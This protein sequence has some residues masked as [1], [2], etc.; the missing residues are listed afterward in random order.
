MKVEYFSDG[1]AICGDST[2]VETFDLVR[3]ELKNEKPTLIISDPPYGNVV[4]DKW[5]RIEEDDKVF[6]QWMIEWTRMWSLLLE[7]GGAFY[8]WGGTGRPG[9]R[10]FFRYMSDVESKG[11]FELANLITWKK[12]RGYG[13][14]NNYLYTREECAY[15]IKGDAKKP[16]TFNV[17]YLEEKRGYSGYD[18]DYPALS[19]FYRRTNVWSDITEILRGKKHPTEKASRVVEIPIEVHTNKGEF[20]ID[21]F[22]GSGATAFACRKLDRKFIVIE[23]DETYFDEMIARLK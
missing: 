7:T 19:E 21:P 14:R 9:F 18:K 3:N 4:K 15:F 12:K 11:F 10:P 1:I 6:S 2:S 8:C 13:V 20:I 22:A 17:P 23:K 5:D 16:R